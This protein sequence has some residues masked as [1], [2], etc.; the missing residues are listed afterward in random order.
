MGHEHID[1]L[2]VIFT[3]DNMNLLATSIPFQHFTG[4]GKTLGCSQILVD[5]RHSADSDKTFI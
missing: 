3:I 4:T 2:S 1:L 5:G